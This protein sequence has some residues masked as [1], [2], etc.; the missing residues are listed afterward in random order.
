VQTQAG[1][2]GQLHFSQ[3]QAAFA[4]PLLLIAAIAAVPE[5]NMT[6]KAL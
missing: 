4:F 5:I 2:F 6:A 3:A 1:V